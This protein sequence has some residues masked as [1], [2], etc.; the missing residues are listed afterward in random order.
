MLRVRVSEMMERVWK[1]IDSLGAAATRRYNSVADLESAP[2]Q[3]LTQEMLVAF[4]DVVQSTRKTSREMDG[5]EWDLERLTRLMVILK[6]AHLPYVL[7]R[8]VDSSDLLHSLGAL[9]YPNSSDYRPDI[10][11][12]PPVQVSMMGQLETYALL[13]IQRY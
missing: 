12:L 3:P 2:Y 8:N 13:F 10:D 5:K 6:G 4:V 11:A 1:A 7:I 9:T